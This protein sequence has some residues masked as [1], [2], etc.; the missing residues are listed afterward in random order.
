MQVAMNSYQ[1]FHI[2]PSRFDLAI[3]KAKLVDL[4]CGE[5]DLDKF[6]GKA[7]GFVC[8]HLNLSIGGFYMNERQNLKVNSKMR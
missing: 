4:V 1:N 2:P 8:Q 7:T 5:K 3:A 6:C